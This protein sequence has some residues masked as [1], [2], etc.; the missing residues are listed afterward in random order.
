MLGIHWP[1]FM[2]IAVIT[3]LVV[4][5]KELPRVLRTFTQIMRKIRGLSKE[6]QDTMSDLAKEADMDDMKDTFKDVESRVADMRVEDELDGTLDGDNK[7]AG[8]FTGNVI[9][10]ELAEDA[11]KKLDPPDEFEEQTEAE[12]DKKSAPKIA[13]SS[14]DDDDAKDGEDD[15][16]ME[17]ST[18]DAPTPKTPNNK[19]AGEA[20]EPET[21]GDNDGDDDD[22]NGDA[23]KA[24]TP[25][26]T[27]D[28]T[29]APPPA[30]A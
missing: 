2:L 12:A 8:M 28:S 19:D 23:K 27:G 22:G 9:G 26:R 30:G 25:E 4:G 6:F 3:V 1:E 13:D 20:V 15:D 18:A 24:A 29:S 10:T 14:E 21:S 11:K 16:G 7:I 17:A 5:P